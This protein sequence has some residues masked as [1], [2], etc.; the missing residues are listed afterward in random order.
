MLIV[1]LD[2][3]D[4]PTAILVV[5]A[6]AALGSLLFSLSQ[7]GPAL[8]ASAAVTCLL[9]AATAVWHTGLVNEFRPILR[10]LYARGEPER[11]H[12]YVRWNSF[13]IIKKTTLEPGASRASSA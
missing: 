12:L 13:S 10:V 11:P 6:F 9:L 1:T 3:T 5:G 7:G 2:V 4:G 8:R